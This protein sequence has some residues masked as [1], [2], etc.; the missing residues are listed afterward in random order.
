MGH[1]DDSER[2]TV[3]LRTIRGLEEELREVLVTVDKLVRIRAVLLRLL[4]ML[5]ELDPDKTPIHPT[6][7]DP[8][9]AYRTSNP[10]DTPKPD[11]ILNGPRFGAKKEGPKDPP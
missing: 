10:P 2:V 1:Q 6:V 5:Q 8:E 7:I 11:S 4:R 9:K 3:P